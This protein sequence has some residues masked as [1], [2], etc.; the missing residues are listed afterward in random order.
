MACF[1]IFTESQPR[2]WARYLKPGFRHVSILTLNDGI[3][4]L[5]RPLYGWTETVS[6]PYREGDIPQTMIDGECLVVPFHVKHCD[7]LR[8]LIGLHT[9]VTTAK[10]YMGI[11]APWII[12]PWQLYKYASRRYAGIIHSTGDTHSG[13]EHRAEAAQTG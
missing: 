7:R 13:S 4:T 12:T 6:C 9:C 3:W 5:T 2:W 1:L 8:S 11:R 10:A